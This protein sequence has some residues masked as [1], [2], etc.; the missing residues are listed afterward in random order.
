MDAMFDRERPPPV[1]VSAALPEDKIVPRVSAPALDCALTVPVPA[2]TVIDPFEMDCADSVTL[3]PE[4]AIGLEPK[5][6]M[7]RA[8]TSDTAPP[9]VV[10]PAPICKS[11][12]ALAASPARLQ[13][14]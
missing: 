4:V 7:L 14:A 8:A 1:L 5:V 6:L 2:A 3:P 11:R 12:P 13:P 9:L 10:M